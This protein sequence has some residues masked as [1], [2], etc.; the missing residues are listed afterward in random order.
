[1]GSIIEYKLEV[2][3]RIRSKVGIQMKGIDK[4]ANSVSAASSK[5]L[6]LVSMIIKSDIEPKDIS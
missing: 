5:S 3:T 4:D 2:P 1:M 6:A